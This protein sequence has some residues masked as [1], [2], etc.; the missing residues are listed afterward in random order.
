MA[1]ALIE[2][3]RSPLFTDTP[4]KDPGRCIEPDDD[5]SVVNGR[6]GNGALEACVSSVKDFLLIPAAAQGNGARAVRPRLSDT[7]HVAADRV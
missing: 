1:D 6:I 3:K 7:L 5:V 2:K 4:G